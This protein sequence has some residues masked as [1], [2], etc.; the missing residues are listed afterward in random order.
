MDMVFTP[1]KI[2]EAVLAVATAASARWDK[3]RNRARATAG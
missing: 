3:F 2:S 1:E